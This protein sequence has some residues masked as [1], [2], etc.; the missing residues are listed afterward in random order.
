MWEIQAVLFDFDDTLQDR[1]AAYRSYCAAFLAEFFST[2]SEEEKARRIDEMESHIEGGYR[3]RED[4]FPEMIALWGWAEHPPLDFLCR[5]FNEHYGEHV[6]LFPDAIPTIERLKAQGYLL[7]I[8][9]NGPSVLQNKKLDTAGIRGLF[10][11]VAVSGDYGIHK[12]DRRLFDLA[13]QKLGVPNESCVFVGDHPVND[14]KGALG[15]DMQ[16][17]WM[18]YGTFA[19]QRTEGVP[20]ITRVSQVIGL[21]DRGKLPRSEKGRDTI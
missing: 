4:Y 18:N 11:V 7:G 8:V 12:P 14:I 9:S 16:A 13:A 21:L 19:G 20:E 10:D 17:V 15:A 5:H 6:A 2:L 3:K 1:E